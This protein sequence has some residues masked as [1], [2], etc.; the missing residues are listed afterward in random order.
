LALKYYKLQTRNI[1]DDS[2][3]EAVK[4][5]TRNAQYN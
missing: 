5:R 1:E 4:K 2:S 3:K